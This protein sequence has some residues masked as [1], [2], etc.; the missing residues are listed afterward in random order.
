M[1]SFS[2]SVTGP[3]MT[4]S[5]HPNP[6]A[7]DTGANNSSPTVARALVSTQHDVI[8]EVAPR[9]RR[10]EPASSIHGEQQLRALPG[11]QPKRL[12]ARA[13]HEPRDR[14]KGGAAAE[15]TVGKRQPADALQPV[16]VEAEGVVLQ[17]LRTV[18][19]RRVGDVGD[20]DG[21]V[22]REGVHRRVAHLQDAVVQERRHV[23]DVPVSTRL[24][25]HITDLKR[26]FKRAGKSKALP[27]Y[28]Q[29]GT[30]VEL[31]SE[32]YSSRL[33]N[34]EHKATL[35]DE[36][37]LDQSLKSYRFSGALFQSPTSVIITRLWCLY[38]KWV[39]Q[40]TTKVLHN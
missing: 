16:R 32:F 5:P 3:N 6:A 20:L 4:G 35:V 39:S 21:L 11:R 19:R 1:T 14:L 33:K 26:H 29:V 38:L 23:S 10:H 17:L 34:R 40:F 28:F 9:E 27:K 25:G 30:V 7:C 12:G 18:E 36:L 15:G 8:A 2:G 13:P 37:L 22:V 31:A 24:L